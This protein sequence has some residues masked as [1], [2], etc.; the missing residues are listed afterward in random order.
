MSKVSCHLKW[1]KS[2]TIDYIFRVSIC[3][4][5]TIFEEQQ[6]RLFIRTEITILSK[7][8]FKLGNI[9]PSHL[10]NSHSM[11]RSLFF[12]MFAPL[13]L[14]FCL[15]LDLS[16]RRRRPDARS[17]LK[18]GPS[19]DRGSVGLRPDRTKCRD[20]ARRSFIDVTRKLD[21]WV[22]VSLILIKECVQFWN[23]NSF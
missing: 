18:N 22:D 3:L 16:R 15:F 20:A 7:K 8:L 17:T 2:K 1:D 14:S 19:S 11:T 5:L 12:F 9:P 21:Y 6:V 13:P 23:L 10:C 4:S